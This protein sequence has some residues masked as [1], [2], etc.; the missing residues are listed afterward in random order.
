MQTPTV[1][2]ISPVSP[3]N[4][5]GYIVINESD[6]TEEHEL[7]VDAK[8]ESGMPEAPLAAPVKKAKAKAVAPEAAPE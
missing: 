3:G 5:H 2:V 8:A 4:P 7:F 1:K 6:L